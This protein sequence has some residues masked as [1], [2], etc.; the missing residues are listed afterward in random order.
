VLL[1]AL[2]VPPLAVA[3]LAGALAA[4]L[5]PGERALL[6]LAGALLVAVALGSPVEPVHDPWTHFLHLR[7]ALAEP[8]RLLDPWDR[9]GFTLLT[10]GPAA[11]GIRAARVSAVAAAL[12]ALAATARAAR[13]LGLRPWLAAALLLAQPDFFGEATSTMTE[14]PFAAALAIGILGVV[15]ERPW[16][17]ATGLGWL[18]ITRPEGPALA[19]LGAIGIAMRFRRAGPALASLLP[20][21][22][23]LAAGAGAFGGL[24]WIL[25]GNPYRGLVG[26]RLDPAALGHS[27]FF[28]ALW[29]S[30][31]P[32]LVALEAAG[33]A[34]AALGP[35]GRFR[36]LLA[37]PAAYVALLTFLSI[38][39]TDAW[40]ESRYLVSIGPALALLAS[41]A[42]DAALA[43][44]PRLAPPLLLGGAALAAAWSTWWQWSRVGA[45]GGALPVLAAA[46][47]CAAA[48]LWRAGGRVSPAVAL[49]A[50]LLAPTLVA[51][52]GVLSRH[53]ALGTAPPERGPAVTAGRAR[54]AVPDAAVRAPAAA[55][56]RSR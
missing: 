43:A 26:L 54:P 8:A 16:L 39:P 12:V 17:A 50:L 44:R 36:F 31:G 19:A 1:A 47:L 23:W 4:S 30:Q 25:S 28:T 32:G 22:A 52:P 55:A 10:A 6:A 9:P 40:H 13:A 7:A 18:A 24:G 33:A 56:R 34:L 49:S 41:A 14:L 42:V 27:Y 45:G 46:A 5:R 29:Q 37:A 21:A 35:P 53:R 2:L 38:G 11:L 3:A 15:E 51:P 20:L 48:L